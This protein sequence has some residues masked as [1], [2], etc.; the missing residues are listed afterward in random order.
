MRLDILLTRLQDLD[1]I[2]VRGR[3]RT[4]STHVLAAVRDLNRLERV[5]ET[6]RAAL[7]SVAVVA[8]DWLQMDAPSA[9]Y[10]RYGHRVENDRFPKTEAARQELAAVIGADGQHLLT[11]IEAA[12]DQPWLSAV[13]AVKILRRVWME[14]Y[15]E[16]EGKLRWRTAEERPAPAELIS[17][18]YDPEARYSTKRSIAWVGYKVHFTETCDPETPH[19]IVNVETT[20][21]STP[22][23]H[24]AAVV[25]ASLAERGR[26][27]DE[28]RVDKGYTCLLYTS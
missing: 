18:P 2:K 5:G 6:L 23:D 14:Q 26:L 20:P 4:D 9:W 28:H 21:A 7:N 16:T 1:L 15:V 13:P 12:I 22:D 25:H 8:P 10:E 24:R 19:L 3:Q 17:S 27:P 11:L